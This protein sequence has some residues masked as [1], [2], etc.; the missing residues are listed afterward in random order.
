M[1]FAGLVDTMA[2]VDAMDRSGVVNLPHNQ[3]RRR[4]S[5]L[6]LNKT[7]S[8]SYNTPYRDRLIISMPVRLVV[9]V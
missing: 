9:G 7:R 5:G 3:K 4:P 1:R 2:K 8:F 6:R